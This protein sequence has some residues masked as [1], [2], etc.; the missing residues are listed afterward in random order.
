MASL[1]ATA[2]DAIVTCDE[3]HQIV[4]FNTAA[5]QMFGRPGRRGAR[6]A[7]EELIPG[8][9]DVDAEASAD[10]GAAGSKRLPIRWEGEVTVPTA[11]AAREIRCRTRM[12]T[13]SRP[14]R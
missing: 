1:V 2:M 7:I 3:M 10:S 5:E 13:A 8:L 6:P 12:S 14:S 11:D 4:V 9:I